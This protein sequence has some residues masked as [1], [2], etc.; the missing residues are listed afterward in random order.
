MD[1]LLLGVLGGWL[2][3]LVV[4]IALCRAAARGDVAMS[5]RR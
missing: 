4:V 1:V 3:I 5:R 2:V